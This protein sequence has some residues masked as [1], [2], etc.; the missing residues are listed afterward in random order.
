M[1][2]SGSPTS[3]GCETIF[4]NAAWSPERR[5]S[6]NSDPKRPVASA[7]KGQYVKSGLLE[8]SDLRTRTHSTLLGHPRDDDS[9][10]VECQG[11]EQPEEV[12]EATED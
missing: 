5:F 12:T 9:R 2:R 7:R 4:I 6:T 3:I 10:I 11:V 1:R 8:D